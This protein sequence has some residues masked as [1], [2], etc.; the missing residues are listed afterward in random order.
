MA[1]VKEELIELVEELDDIGAAD[2]L[3][4]AR[5]RLTDQEDL[6]A[7]EW[8]EVRLGKEQIARGESVMLADLLRQ[9]G[10]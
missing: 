6:T 7:E 2:L 1:T 8:D 4:Y 9:L 3:D 10:E 5:W